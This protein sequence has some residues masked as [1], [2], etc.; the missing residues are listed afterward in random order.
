MAGE[1]R[2]FSPL[3]GLL[4]ECLESYGTAGGEAALSRRASMAWFSVNGDIER[5]HTVCVFVRPSPRKGRAPV[6]FVYVDSRTRAVDF[7]VNREIYLGR[8]AMAGLEFSEVRFLEDRR[9]R[10]RAASEP[11]SSRTSERPS[12]ALPDLPPEEVRRVERM[13]AQLPESLRASASRAMSISLRR[14]LS[15]GAEMVEMPSDNLSGP[16]KRYH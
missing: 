7:S 2:D 10:G 6:L 15:E 8:L 14:D 3:G 11:A 5:A 12:R 1:D 13:C 16:H 9:G 4:S